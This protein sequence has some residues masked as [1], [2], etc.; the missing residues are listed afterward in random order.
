MLNADLGIEA[1]DA[2]DGGGN[3]A[4]GNGNP[5]QC[6]GVACTPAEQCGDGIDNDGDG[7]VDAADSGCADAADLDEHSP[8]LA[9]DDGAD[10]DGD[11]AIDFL[12]LGGGDPGCAS[13]ISVRENPQ[14]QDGLNNDNQ[15][16]IDFD[17]GASLDLD[18][19]GSIDAE[20]NPATPVVGAADPECLG[21]PDRNR[22]AP[23]TCGLGAEL[24][25]VM[26]VLGLAASRRRRGN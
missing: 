9:C 3:R 26:P 5:L 16:G 19:D 17:G 2:I 8:T 20:F 13:P 4:S 11:G 25:L 21:K 7:F 22:E 1:P 18:N 15:T 6:V 10:N 12:A 24:A 23:N 14:C